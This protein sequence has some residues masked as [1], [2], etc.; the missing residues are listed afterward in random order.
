[1][2]SAAGKWHLYVHVGI[3]DEVGPVRDLFDGLH[4]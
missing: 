3:S 4:G 2:P 1:M